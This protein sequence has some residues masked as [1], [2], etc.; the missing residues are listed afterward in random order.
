LTIV[1][2]A[3]GEEGD[4]SGTDATPVV[5]ASSSPAAVPTAP[6]SSP[7]A[8]VE[9]SS[10]DLPVISGRPQ[11]PPK[12]P[13]DTFHAVTIRGRVEVGVEAGCVEL[14]TAGGRYVLLGDLVG[15]L[16]AG[17]EIE[18]DAR[19]A[20]NAVTTCQG[21]SAITVTAVRHP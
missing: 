21:D 4:G 1:A 15:D 6:S 17:E 16:A 10:T 14:V 2:L 3:C 13:T 19:A 5:V 20:P 12:S 11:S 8:T 7:P 18:V 9:L